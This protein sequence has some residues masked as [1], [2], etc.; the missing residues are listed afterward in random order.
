MHEHRGDHTQTTDPKT[1]GSWEMIPATFNNAAT[2]VALL[3][4]NK[5]FAF[6]GSS[7]DFDRFS[8]PP[9]P[10]I[11]DLATLE[12]RVLGKENVNGDIW[13]GGHTFLA[14]GQLLFVGGTG[15]YPPA[16][17]PF[18]G[19]LR[20]A[21]LFDPETETWTRLPDMRQGRWY[22][23]LIRLADN[24]VLSISGL[25]HRAPD[26]GA[27]RGN[28]L[29]V[30]WDLLTKIKER[31]V[32][33][34]EVFDPATREW[35]ALPGEKIFPLYP[36]LHLLPDGDVFYSGVFNTHYFTPGKF[37]SARWDHN[38]QEWRELGGRHRIKN[39]EEGISLLLALRPPD[40]QAQV[41]IAGGGHHN[42][43][44]TIQSILHAI[45][46]DSWAKKLARFTTAQ[47]TVEFIDMSEPEPRWQA[48]ADMHHPRIHAVG[49]LLPDGQVATI[50]GMSGHGH[51]EGPD[52][53][54]VLPAEIYDPA[55]DRWSLQAKPQRPRVYHSTALLL[56]DGRVIS[57]GGNPQAKV[58]EHSIEIYSPPYLFRGDRPMVM[59]HPGEITYGEEFQVKTDN[60]RRV[61]QVVLMR[62]EVL[63]HV[64][65]SD[66]R[67][68]EL[69]YRR[70]DEEKLQVAGPPTK[71]LMPQGYA[72]LFLLNQDGVPSIGKFIKVH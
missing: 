65:N 33:E 4:T 29:L 13:C 1:M 71:A 68:L 63:T 26:E 58:I 51:G 49:V 54:P 31:L 39:R 21:Y 61:T 60:A 28:L 38:T 8:D 67:L 47:N 72:L 59:E 50:G 20:E 30:I 55:A 14:D 37:P 35:S 23:T 2:H 25:Q 15:L 40:Y 52:D 12:T 6:G 24:R 22:P 5:V 17:D 32:S 10:E 42:L 66:Q 64:T 36:R 44:R 16:P 27:S 48:R 9:P 3:P 19:G 46:L 70:Q 18:Y 11:L 43:P 45:G 69:E 62:P 7:L 34:Q 57:M 41:L 53:Y 56:P